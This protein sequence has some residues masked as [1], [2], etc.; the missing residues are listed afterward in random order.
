MLK[1]VIN[2][3]SM[4]GRW[5]LVIEGT[6][7]IGVQPRIVGYPLVEQSV[8]RLVGYESNPTIL[9]IV[10]CS[11]LGKL[12]QS[13]QN[14]LQFFFAY[15]W[16]LLHKLSSKLENYESLRKLFLFDNPINYS[17]S[18]LDIIICQNCQDLPAQP[19]AMAPSCGTAPGHFPKVW[20]RMDQWRA[21]R[22][23]RFAAWSCWKCP[24][25]GNSRAAAQHG[26]FSGSGIRCSVADQRSSHNPWWGRRHWG[27]G[28]GHWMLVGRCHQ[29]PRFRAMS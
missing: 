15:S 1:H 25:W 23:P 18:K 17:I 8:Y 9:I 5:F 27:C 4:I 29:E 20:L 3:R 11:L 26:T 14:N 6:S 19:K 22:S 16:S 28:E 21:P 7:S 2:G 13:S 12:R 24:M 10:G